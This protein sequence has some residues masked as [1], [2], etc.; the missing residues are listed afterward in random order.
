MFCLPCLMGV[1]VDT[2]SPDAAGSHNPD[3]AAGFSGNP[4]RQQQKADGKQGCRQLQR[5]PLASKPRCWTGTAEKQVD[6][7]APG[8][9]EVT[10]GVHR[11]NT[12]EDGRGR[13]QVSPPD[14]GRILLRADGPAGQ[15]FL[16]S[17]PFSHAVTEVGLFL[18]LIRSSGSLCDL[19]KA[20]Q[21]VNDGAEKS[22][23]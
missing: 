20:T 7:S 9:P 5:L 16:H 17:H 14:W 1:G 2:H 8:L 21:S 23:S 13:T 10:G 6:V 4:P 12:P 3:T 15:H 22:C 11:P 19:S 18:V